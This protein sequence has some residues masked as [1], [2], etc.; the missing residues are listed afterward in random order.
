[1]VDTPKF[2]KSAVAAIES[3]TGDGRPVD[4][5]ILT[6]VDDTAGHNDWKD[7]YPNLQRIFHS[8]DLGKHNWVGDTTLEHVEVLLQ[9]NDDSKDYG[10]DEVLKLMMTRN[11]FIFQHLTFMETN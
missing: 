4:C 11:Q 3:L 7:H 9:T 6:H 1:M 10:D 2:S 5:L 8:G